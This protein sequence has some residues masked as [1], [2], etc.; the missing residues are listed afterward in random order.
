MQ[1]NPSPVQL[2]FLRGRP[3]SII[4]SLTILRVDVTSQSQAP[5]VQ[6]L[7]NNSTARSELSF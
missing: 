2:Y 7:A 4:A 1:S 3:Q 6:A 5:F